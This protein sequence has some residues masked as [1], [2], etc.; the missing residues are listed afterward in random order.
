MSRMAKS[1]LA[2]VLH[3][4]QA[5]IGDGYL[6]QAP[7]VQNRNRGLE[8]SQLS[9]IGLSDEGEDFLYNSETILEL[10]TASQKNPPRKFEADDILRAIPGIT[11]CAICCRI[12]SSACG[13]FYDGRSALFFRSLSPYA[14]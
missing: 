8:Y 12:R 13:L 1:N 6:S 5:F 11:A 9:C 3:P 7:S 2:N 4:I 14:I 10:G